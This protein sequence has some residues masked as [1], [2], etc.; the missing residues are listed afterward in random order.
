MKRALL[1][2][3]GAVLALGAGATPARAA[4]AP[5]LAPLKIMPL[6]DSITFGVGSRTTSSYRVDL[7]RRLQT[8]GLDVD[9]VGSQSSGSGGTDLDHEG[10]SGFVID[11]LTR[12]IDGWLAT[13]A[14]DAVLLMA[15]TNDTARSLDLATAPKRLATLITRIRTARPSAHVFVATIVGQR[16]AAGQRNA[17]AFNAR[18]PGIVAAQGNRVHLVDQSSVDGRDLRDNLHPDD[19]G[20]AKMSHNWYRALAKVYNTT[21]TPWPTGVNPYTA[22]EAYHCVL[23]YPGRITVCR[24][25]HLRAV[26]A[27][28]K[29]KSVTV[30]RWQTR[31]FIT[32]D[33]RRVPVWSNT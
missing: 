15:G 32:R 17:D 28:V 4:D 30:K 7:R 10:H 2:A 22:T 1:C 8:A 24:W 23:T 27:T 9:F 3:L 20:F 6:G 11:Q 12:Q 18:V 19:V 16:D 13:S 14:P 5:T 21:G 33:N 25:W 29:G 31:R 26:R